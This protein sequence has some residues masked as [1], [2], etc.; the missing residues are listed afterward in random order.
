VAAADGHKHTR[1]DTDNTR[2]IIMM[3]FDA[4]V[5]VQQLKGWNATL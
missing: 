1:A 2:L 5:H 4:I 3:V